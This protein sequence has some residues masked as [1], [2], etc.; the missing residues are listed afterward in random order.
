MRSSI[1][2]QRKLKG[3]EIRPYDGVSLNVLFA[4]SLIDGT[5]AL[6]CCALSGYPTGYGTT[7]HYKF[8]EQYLPQIQR[9]QSILLHKIN[10]TEGSVSYLNSF[11]YYVDLAQD[12]TIWDDDKPSTYHSKLR[13]SGGQFCAKLPTGWV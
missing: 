8:L 1:I 6:T 3:V 9:A 5:V 7:K 13:A 12:P 4:I 10:D 11:L 2:S